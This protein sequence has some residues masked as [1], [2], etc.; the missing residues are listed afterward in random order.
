MKFH[1]DKCP[2]NFLVVSI[3]SRFT[4]NIRFMKAPVNVDH[5]NYRAAL[6][7]SQVVVKGNWTLLYIVLF[8]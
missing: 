8:T 3:Y 1:E 4:S 7:V 5:I 6:D 2:S